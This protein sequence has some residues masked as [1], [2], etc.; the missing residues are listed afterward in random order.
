M[1]VCTP[2]ISPACQWHLTPPPPPPPRPLW[3][4]RLPQADHFLP[5]HPQRRRQ[6]DVVP[7]RRAQGRAAGRGG[8]QGA[9]TRG[10][11][12]RAISRRGG[13]RLRRRELARPPHRRGRRRLRR[14]AAEEEE[15]ASAPSVGRGGGPITPVGACRVRAGHTCLLLAASLLPPTAEGRRRLSSCA[16]SAQGLREPA[17]RAQGRERGR[18][19]DRERGAQAPQI[20]RA[21]R[22]G[23]RCERALSG[24][25]NLRQ[26]QSY[27]W[28]VGE[29]E[30]RRPLRASTRAESARE[31]A[32]TGAQCQLW[33]LGCRQQHKKLRKES[34]AHK[35]VCSCRSDREHSRALVRESLQLYSCS[36]RT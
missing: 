12:A 21:E 8:R 15:R 33:G 9:A 1:G 35:T 5:Q 25:S 13:L 32:R 4:G 19:G 23:R 7:A 6:G 31:A 16:A 29:W 3:A 26:R 11:R 24:C 14:G 2:P 22:A 10:A 18:G 30:R 28:R 17:A 27:V 20:E 34:R 36:I